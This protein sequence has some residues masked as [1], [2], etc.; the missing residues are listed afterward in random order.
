MTRHLFAFFIGI[1]ALSA[2]AAAEEKIDCIP[3]RTDA[4][5]PFY[6]SG[7]P[8]RSRVGS[9]YLVQGIV[10]SAEDCRPLAGA[11]IEFWMAGPEG[12]YLDAYRATV[13]ADS[14]ARFRFE[15]HIPVGYSGRPPHIHM[16]ITAFGHKTLVTQ[17]YPSR[18]QKDAE[19]D[20][21]LAPQ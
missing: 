11:M 9:G 8:R 13:I 20:L 14:Q 1:L 10:R 4:L 16:R 3:T 15:S 6:K 19:F 5:G 17:H 2:I 18:D 21:V 12:R 7:A